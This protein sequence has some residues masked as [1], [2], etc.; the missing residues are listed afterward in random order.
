MSLKKS[1]KCHSDCNTLKDG[2]SVS[3]IICA[4]FA[5]S[6]R[7]QWPRVTPTDWEVYRPPP[8]NN[9][10]KFKP[11]AT[12]AF[13]AEVFPLFW[14]YQVSFRLPWQPR[15]FK[16]AEGKIESNK[17]RHCVQ[18][19]NP[20]R[21]LRLRAKIR[22]WRAALLQVVTRGLNISSPRLTQ[23]AYFG[24][25]LRRGNIRYNE[26]FTGRPS[27][28]PR[29][30]VLLHTAHSD[31][32]LS[33]TCPNA[34]AAWQDMRRREKKTWLNHSFFYFFFFAFHAEPVFVQVLRCIGAH[35]HEREGE[36]DIF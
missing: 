31:W 32:N 26:T 25:C 27:F 14:A 16:L 18:T 24:E 19:H 15:S 12:K 21:G 3:P 5:N 34:S 28:Q 11:F 30:A 20:C 17:K 8:A 33:A 36:R 13:M 2:T 29:S 10:V 1:S 6:C 23:L 35:I 22:K 9:L 7:K 4:N